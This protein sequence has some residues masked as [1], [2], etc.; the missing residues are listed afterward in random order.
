MFWRIIQLGVVEG[1]RGESWSEV[2][3]TVV[4]KNGV[5][6][7]NDTGENLIGL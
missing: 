7:K 3:D 1:H 2:V 4:G 5:T 6:G